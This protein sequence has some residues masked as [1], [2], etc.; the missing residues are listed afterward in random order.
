MIPYSYKN[1]TPKMVILRCIGPNNFFVEKAI[2]SCETYSLIAPYGSRIEIWGS[3]K[4]SLFLEERHRLS[5]PKYEI[6]EL[7]AA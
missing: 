3:N 4:D 2:L 7:Y 1:E 6:N 5:Q